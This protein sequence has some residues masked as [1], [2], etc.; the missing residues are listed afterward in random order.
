MNAS[1]IAY[2]S[3][4]L[5]QRYPAPNAIHT[6]NYSSIE[7]LDKHFNSGASL[8]FETPSSKGGIRNFV[9]VASMEVPYKGIDDL[10]RAFALV[11]SECPDFS[12]TV[13]GDGALRP[14]LEQMARDLDIGD[15]CKFTGRL[16]AGDAVRD[17]LDKADCFVLPSRTEGLP[18]AMIEAMARGL[19]C[20]GTRVGGIPELLPAED[21]VSANDPE[22][23]AEKLLEVSSNPQR[24]ARMSAR[25]LE[26]AKEYRSDAL[27][28]R[29]VEMY[30]RLKE[31]SLEWQRSTQN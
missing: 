17:V 26:V 4:K 6:T 30:T 29:R 19:P 23:L 7:L 2:V 13:V 14:D 10:L 12:L 31:V 9:T 16:P 21:M 3:A 27:Q 1:T 22:A 5:T 20:V 24:M 18:R 25:N 15:S 8:R 11:L 28:A